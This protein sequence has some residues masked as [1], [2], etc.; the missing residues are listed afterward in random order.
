MVRR[1]SVYKHHRR[2]LIGCDELS[3]RVASAEKKNPAHNP[4]D[5]STAKSHL[6]PLNMASA[7]EPSDVPLI[8]E[9]ME[10]VPLDGE[11]LTVEFRRGRETRPT[12]L[13]TH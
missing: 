12:A 11:F 13:E 4:E 9:L 8:V 7:D 2:G 5:T 1:G 3:I 6:V 10:K